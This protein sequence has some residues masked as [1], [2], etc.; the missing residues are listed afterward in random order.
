MLKAKLIKLIWKFPKDLKIE[1]PIKQHHRYSWS[2]GDEWFYLNWF[3]GEECVVK[4]Y[5]WKIDKTPH[6]TC[7]LL[8]SK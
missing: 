7:L 5:E 4:I 3:Y 8:S 1:I 2:K 6:T